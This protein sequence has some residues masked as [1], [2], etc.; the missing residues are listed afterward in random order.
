M[1][2]GWPLRAP[3]EDGGP[4][5]GVADAPDAG[6]GEHGE[7]DGEEELAGGAGAAEGEGGPDRDEEEAEEPGG[8]AEL[9]G[10]VLVGP[11]ALAQEFPAGPKRAGQAE[12]GQRL[13]GAAEQGRAVARRAGGGDVGVGA[14]LG[15]GRYDRGAHGAFLSR[16]RP[17]RWGGC[18]VWCGG[19][20]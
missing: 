8:L 12:D 1:L 4:V 10:P 11:G 20:R 9:P 17:A 19:R 3:G 5:V 15:V 7:A 13:P 16:R 2:R 6:P 14:V 18:W